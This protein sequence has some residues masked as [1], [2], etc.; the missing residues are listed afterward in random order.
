MVI[1]A[2]S[3]IYLKSF[4]RHIQQN[5]KQI[6]QI[7]KSTCNLYSGNS[8]HNRTNHKYKKKHRRKRKQSNNLSKK[9]KFSFM[10]CNV[11]SLKSKLKSFE[12]V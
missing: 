12:N 10:N 2:N 3:F 4:F 9:Q 5:H 7:R 8:K 11:A 1:N 6:K